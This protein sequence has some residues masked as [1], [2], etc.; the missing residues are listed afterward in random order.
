MNNLAPIIVVAGEPFSVFSEIFFKA[1]KKNY[2]KNSKRPIIL[3]SS[4]KL[5]TQQ[6]LKLNFNYKFN[7]IDKNLFKLSLIDNKKINLINVDF[8]YRK[9]FD[10]ISTKSNSYIEKCFNIALDLMKKKKL[11]GFNQWSNF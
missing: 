8:N 11:C 9:P 2:I 3:I 1:L 4:L 10:K 6:M 5:I 7:V